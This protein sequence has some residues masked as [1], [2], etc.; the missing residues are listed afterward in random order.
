MYQINALN[1]FDLALGAVQAAGWGVV[2]PLL[3]TVTPH[4]LWQLQNNVTRNV[5]AL[6]LDFRRR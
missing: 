3:R 2:V 6:H 1:G 5:A 4:P